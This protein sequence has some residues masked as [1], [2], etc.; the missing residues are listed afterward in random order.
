LELLLAKHPTENCYYR[1]FC[2]AVGSDSDARSEIYLIDYGKDIIVDHKDL[3]PIPESLL[4]PCI[5]RLFKIKLQ[6][7]RNIDELDIG[8]S[9]TKFGKNPTFSAL[10][11]EDLKTIT[12]ADSIFVFKN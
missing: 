10:V 8:K 9:L 2:K 5:A 3:K 11:H 6:S 12:A 4:Q 7:G 1:G